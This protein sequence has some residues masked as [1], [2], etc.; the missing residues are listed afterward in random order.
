MAETT[1]ISWTDATFNP[2]IGCTKVGPGCDHCYAE[3]DFDLRKGRVKWGAGN[4]RSR[5]SS[6]NWNKPL[7][8]ERQHSAFAAEHGRRR[9]VFCASLADVFDNEAPA[10]WRA[11]LMTLIRETPSLDWLLLTKRISNVQRMVPEGLPRNVWLGATMVTRAE[12]LRDLDRLREVPASI[13]FVSAEPLLEDVGDVDLHGIDWLIAGGESGP[14]ARPM[15][16]AWVRGL[17][18]LCARDGVAFH[19]KQWGGKR[20]K[21]GG[22]LL[23]GMEAKAW[24]RAA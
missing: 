15:D 9:R 13:H 12:F 23:D 17:G 18:D 19:F 10:E 24:P 22:C 1:D 21:D 20:P 7:Q 8:W 3:R 4:A 11:D 2:W 6:A 16:A 5:T 14:Q